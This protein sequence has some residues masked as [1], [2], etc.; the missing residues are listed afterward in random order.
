MILLQIIPLENKSE[1]IDASEDNQCIPDE[2]H[3]DDNYETNGTISESL[4]LDDTH[5]IEGNGLDSIRMNRECHTVGESLRDWPLSTKREMLEEHWTSESGNT[6]K[7]KLNRSFSNQE[8]VQYKMYPDDCLLKTNATKT[9]ETKDNNTKETI[10]VSGQTDSA[11]TDEAINLIPGLKPPPTEIPP[12]LYSPH[13]IP[14]HVFQPL[15]YHPLPTYADPRWLKIYG[16]KPPI[17]SM[18]SV[19]RQPLDTHLLRRVYA[20]LDAAHFPKRNLA[21]TS[22][23]EAV[24]AI[25]LDSDMYP[26]AIDEYSQSV[27]LDVHKQN[28]IVEDH[29]QNVTLGGQNQSAILDVHS[30]SDTVDDHKHS[31]TMR[32][33]K[34]T[35]VPQD[36]YNHSSIQHNEETVSASPKSKYTQCNTPCV[37]HSQSN[38]LSAEHTHSTAENAQLEPFH[39]ET[40]QDD[41]QQIKQNQF[42]T[43]HVLQTAAFSNSDAMNSEIL[44]E[45]DSDSI[46]STKTEM[47]SS[48]VSV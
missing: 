32:D 38:A 40:L 7:L 15:S 42:L 9:E 18:E 16:G 44:S 23:A 27:A 17:T 24:L 21:D 14:P 47:Y 48:D 25:P 13:W 4:T 29:Q 41:P 35:P 34:Q 3:F 8:C 12:T 1:E 11:K 19:F 36:N 37:E 28:N 26:H 6:K 30:H 10:S 22:N 5:H 46:E 39:D 31:V 20:N 2:K 43:S 45:D 33:H